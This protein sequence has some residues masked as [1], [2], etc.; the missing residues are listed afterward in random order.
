MQMKNQMK[1]IPVLFLALAPVAC[2]TMSPTS[3]DSESMI[4]ESQSSTVSAAGV[5][6]ARRGV[7]P[8]ICS[9]TAIVLTASPEDPYRITARFVDSTGKFAPGECSGFNW[10]VSPSGA[11]VQPVATG[12][13]DGSVVDVVVSGANQTYTVTATAN[14]LQAS[15]DIVPAGSSTETPKLGG[16]ARRPMGPSTRICLATSITLGVDPINSLRLIARVSDGA[17]LPVSLAGCPIT[18]SASPEGAYVQPLQLGT[19]DSQIAD[20]II[21]GARKSYTVTASTNGLSASVIV[22]LKS[23]GLPN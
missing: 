9:A 7:P 16:R 17:G 20:L 8:P 4:V 23:A 10:T 12:T 15:I 5:Q 1:A 14:S 2:G 21:V 3:P 13:V 6:K 22:N 11:H 18:W 19:A